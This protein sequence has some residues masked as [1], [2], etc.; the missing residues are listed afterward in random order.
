MNLYEFIELYEFRKWLSQKCFKRSYHKVKNDVKKIYLPKSKKNFIRFIRYLKKIVNMNHFT[1]VTKRI[2][3]IDK[4]K[5][6]L[7]VKIVSYKLNIL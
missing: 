1:D 2:H 7:K 5:Y 3:C 6:T 4:F